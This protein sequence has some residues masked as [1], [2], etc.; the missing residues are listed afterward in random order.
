RSWTNIGKQAVAGQP[1]VGGP[2]NAVGW[3]EGAAQARSATS[4]GASS[5]GTIVVV[6]LVAILAL[7]LGFFPLLRRRVRRR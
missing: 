3:Y 6:A 7:A 2:F 5:G 1:F 4:G